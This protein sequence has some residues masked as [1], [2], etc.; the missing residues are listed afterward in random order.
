LFIVGKYQTKRDNGT[1]EFQQAY[2][3]Y[4]GYRQTYFLNFANAFL[5]LKK[6]PT[7]LYESGVEIV[8]ESSTDDES[9]ESDD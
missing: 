9:D 4:N 6:H 1:Y 7:G 5:H 8:Y 3:Y 2:K